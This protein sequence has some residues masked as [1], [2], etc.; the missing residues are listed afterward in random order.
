MKRAA[1]TLIETVLA[2]GIL[3]SVLTA[4]IGLLPHALDSTRQADAR[5]VEALI[6]RHTGLRCREGL[7]SMP[8]L[9]DAAGSPLPAGSP[10]AVFSVAVTMNPAA[11]LPGGPPGGL[12]QA[13]LEI[14]GREAV[15]NRVILLPP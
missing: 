15:R 4:V 9:F 1:H 13:R 7:P 14:R 3:A 2:L 8:L 6:V 11:A 5:L 12:R 10:D